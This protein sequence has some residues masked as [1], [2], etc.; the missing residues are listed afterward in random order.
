MLDGMIADLRGALDAV[1]RRIVAA[2]V[3]G[4]L[5]LAGL[6]FAAAALW[7]VAAA[8]W[9]PAASSLLLAGLCVA[10]AAASA[11]VWRIAAGR[12]AKATEAARARTA[13]RAEAL[14]TAFR[15]GA[16]IGGRLSRR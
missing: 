9:G 6:G 3:I 7:T 1:G 5:A 8:A 12:E 14:L 4:V 10:A 2:L 15:V 16:E 13:A 11:L